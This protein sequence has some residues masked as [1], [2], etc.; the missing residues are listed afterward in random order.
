MGEM[1]YLRSVEKWLTFTIG[2]G[3]QMRF[4]LSEGQQKDAGACLAETQRRIARLQNPDKYETE[5]RCKRSWEND[6]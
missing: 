2:D 5:C 3:G 4:P 1:E 6:G